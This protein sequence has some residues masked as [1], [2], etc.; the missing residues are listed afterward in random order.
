MFHRHILP[1]SLKPYFIS[2][3][4]VTFFR[5]VLPFCLFIYYKI[6]LCHFQYK[7]Q[8]NCQPKTATQPGKYFRKAI[9]LFS[10]FYLYDVLWIRV[11]RILFAVRSDH[12]Y[13]K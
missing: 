5:F 7:A 1:S 4:P 3:K 13:S 8:N 11:C 6:S 2:Q 9:L 12:L 10:S